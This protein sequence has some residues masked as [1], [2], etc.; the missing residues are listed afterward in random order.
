MRAGMRDGRAAD[1]GN[2]EIG[3]FRRALLADEDIFRLHVS[4]HDAV[5]MNDMQRI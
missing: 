3:Q 1:M 2:A 5:L 4:M